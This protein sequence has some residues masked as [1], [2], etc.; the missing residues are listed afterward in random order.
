[1]KIKRRI[2]QDL[3]RE[4]EEP[5]ILILTG[6]RQVGKTTLLR[7]LDAAAREAGKKTRYL[8]L[9]Q[10]DDLAALKGD[11]RQIID[12][13]TRGSRRPENLDRTLKKS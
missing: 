2:Y 3:W 8:D 11:K 13:L 12:A 9:E 7:A 4:I 6:P 10:P 5:Q 1:M